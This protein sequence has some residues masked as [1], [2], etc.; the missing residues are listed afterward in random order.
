[1]TA[2]RCNSPRV[3]AARSVRTRL[4]FDCTSF[5]LEQL[6][7]FGLLSL[8]ANKHFLAPLSLLFDKKSRAGLG[9]F[10]TIFFQLNDSLWE[11]GLFAAPCVCFAIDEF[12][13]SIY[14]TTINCHRAGAFLEIEAQIDPTVNS[15]DV[16]LGSSVDFSLSGSEL[17]SRK[18][19]LKSLRPAV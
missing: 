8:R 12:C 7:Q 13:S 6:C 5:V 2:L 15:T 11:V 18:S 3:A 9:L 16:T 19:K 17:A 10:E 1:M 4:L 14:L